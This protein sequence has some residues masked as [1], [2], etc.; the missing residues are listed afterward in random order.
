MLMA[1]A[2]FAAIVVATSFPFQELLVQRHQLAATAAEL[3]Q[4]RA[5]NQ[6]LASQ[7]RR[8]ANPATVDNLAARDYGLL[9]PGEQVYNVIPAPGSGESS[10]VVPLGGGPVVPGSPESAA[11]LGAAPAGSSAPGTESSGSGGSASAH[12]GPAQDGRPATDRGFWA[13]VTRTLEFW[14]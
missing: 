2:V 13:R 12:G 6:A 14:H 1:S 4:L 5:G 10:A 8:L 9:P 7:E 11:R 3:S